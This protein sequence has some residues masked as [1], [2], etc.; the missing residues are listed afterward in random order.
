MNILALGSDSSI[1]TEGSAARV[2]Q[3]AYADEAAKQGGTFH[4]VSRAP[5]DMTIVDGSLTLH[6]MRAGRI[7]MLWKV[8]SRTRRIIREQDV[9]I[10]S[11][12][13]PF[14]H[15]WMARRAVSGTNAKLHIQVHT[16][17]LS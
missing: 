4:I 15:G 7:S 14:E 6:G 17:F 2:R 8:P 1:F 10:V 9:S 11:A 12:Q 13:D 3:R 16:D 5:K